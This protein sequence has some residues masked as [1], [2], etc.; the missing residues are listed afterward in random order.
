MRGAA[1]EDKNLKANTNSRAPAGAPLLKGLLIALAMM[2]KRASG[3]VNRARK[4]VPLGSQGS[5][6]QFHTS[7]LYI[8]IYICSTQRDQNTTLACKMLD[9]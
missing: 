6:I 2:H 1:E 7:E 5:L 4:G 9:N 8:Y 3:G